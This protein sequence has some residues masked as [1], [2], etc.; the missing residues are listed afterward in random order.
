MMQ[1]EHCY[2]SGKRG[3][4]ERQRRR[5]RTNH[6][7]TIFVVPRIPSGDEI[8]VI[9]EARYAPR[10][11]TQSICHGARSGTHFQEVVPQIA[12]LQNPRQQFLLRDLLPEPRSTKPF[13][14]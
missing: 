5:V 1:Y 9:F 11:G 12:G 10:V 2:D 13:F 8:V 7:D 3:T 6:S 4:A 14:E